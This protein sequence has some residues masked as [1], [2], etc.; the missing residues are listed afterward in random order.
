MTIAPLRLHR[1][2]PIS[3]AAPPASMPTGQASDRDAA[4]VDPTAVD[5]ARALAVA[6]TEVLHGLRPV[7]RLRSWITPELAE[8]LI[9]HQHL[10][11]RLQGSR[12]GA[13]TACRHGSASL[14][15]L[16]PDIVEAAV[17]VHTT[18]RS[19]AVALRLHRRG[20]RWKVAEFVTA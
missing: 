17:V 7:T 11:A 2:A 19:R 16:S 15:Q 8:R 4:C 14:T 5:A 1:P 18:G 3:I 10:R 9:A 6:L 13:V 20:G 12:P